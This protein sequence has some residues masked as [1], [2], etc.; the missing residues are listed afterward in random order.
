[1]LSILGSI[2]YKDIFLLFLLAVTI[3]KYYYSVVGVIPY[4][5]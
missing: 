2:V 1:M 4:I 5:A 3:I